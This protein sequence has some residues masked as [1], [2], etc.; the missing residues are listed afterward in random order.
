VDS[1]LLAVETARRNLLQNG[2][3]EDRFCLL[4]GSLGAAFSRR[5]RFDVVVANILSDVILRLLDD[6]VRLLAP[7]GRFICSGIIE[8]H[9][10][11]VIAKMRTTGLVPEDMAAE[12]AWVCIAGSPGKRSGCVSE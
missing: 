3:P 5:A 4:A 11:A 7:G 12:D 6:V 1:D 10:D 2:V 9:R 8:D